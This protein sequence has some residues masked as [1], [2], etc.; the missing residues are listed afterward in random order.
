MGRG[1]KEQRDFTEPGKT[2]DTRE[3]DIRTAVE[4]TAKR[5]LRVQAG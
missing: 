5:R 4:S 3:G 1:S 2:A